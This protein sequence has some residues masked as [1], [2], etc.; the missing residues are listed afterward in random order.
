MGCQG[1]PVDNGGAIIGLGGVDGPQAL[2]GDLRA[3]H[4]PYE[5]EALTSHPEVLPGIVD[6]IAELMRT[7]LDNLRFW[8]RRAT[9]PLILLY[10]GDLSSRLELYTVVELEPLIGSGC[11]T[12]CDQHPIGEDGDH[13]TGYLT[14]KV[15]L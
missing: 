4:H 13:A 14:E 12:C 9:L 3:G 1:L 6:R 10:C 11:L 8:R 2:Y 5:G 7:S 15:Y